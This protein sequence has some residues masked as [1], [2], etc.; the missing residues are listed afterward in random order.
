M[1]ALSCFLTLSNAL[2]TGLL[3]AYRKHPAAS[4]KVTT[5]TATS[6]HGAV[7]PLGRQRRPEHH[8]HAG[9][10]QGHAHE[11]QGR[12]VQREAQAPGR[13]RLLDF[14]ADQVGV[15]LDVIAEQLRLGGDQAKNRVDHRAA[16]SRGQSRD[17]R[18]SSATRPISRAPVAAAISI[19]LIGSS[20]T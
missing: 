2:S 4:T 5:G 13:A 17:E 9:Q 6:T 16:P 1:S 15:G 10:D 19:A 7:K 20:L 11:A 18:L 8:G 12:G 3:R 14:L